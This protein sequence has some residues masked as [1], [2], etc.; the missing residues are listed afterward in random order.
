MAVFNALIVND[1]NGKITYGI[2]EIT[3]NQLSEGNVIVEVYY[4]SVNYK[5]MLAVEKNGG[6]I[7]QYPM[8][9]GIDAS[10]RVVSSKHPYFKEGQKVL[11]TGF[12]FG[13]SHTGGYSEYIRVPAEWLVPI[14]EGLGLKEAMMIGTAGF[15]AALSVLRLEAGGMS[16]D[17]QP[18]ILVTGATGG[19]GSIA[20]HILHK[21]GY[22]NIIAMSRKVEQE[23][24]LKSLGA[25]EVC[26]PDQILANPKKPLNK[27]KYHY[28][29]DTVGGDVAANLI[30]QIYYGGG[31]SMCGNASGITLNTTVLPFILRGIAL[32]G[33]DSVQFPINQRGNVWRKFVDKWQLPEMFNADVVT[34]SQLPTVFEKIKSGK[35][36]GRT[37][38]KVKE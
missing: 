38:V 18:A 8:I 33:I 17:A 10:G 16:V 3:E 9:P 12:D 11:I 23:N 24:W 6:V 27:Q 21:S 34:L 26:Q 1:Q 37:V 35:H 31:M 30:S 14:P 28:I 22:K 29:I 7:R 13:I 4:S 5:D 25:K 2:E 19:V 32:F 36:I 15:T 20:V